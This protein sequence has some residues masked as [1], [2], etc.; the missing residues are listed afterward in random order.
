MAAALWS[1][2]VSAPSQVSDDRSD[3]A[4]EPLVVGVTWEGQGVPLHHGH[5]G[6]SG[7]GGAGRR[8]ARDVRR[9]RA[10]EV[11][12]RYADSIAADRLG[13]RGLA[14]EHPRRMR[15]VAVT[16]VVVMGSGGVLAECDVGGI[17]VA[18]GRAEQN[19]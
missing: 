17:A 5:S 19:G 14:F 10:V 2:A 13:M 9:G 12:Q 11:A 8:V 3:R 4:V 6:A 18:V 7:A 16:K 15:E 1:R